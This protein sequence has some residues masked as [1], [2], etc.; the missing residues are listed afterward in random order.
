[1]KTQKDQLTE[2]QRLFCEFYV[3]PGKHNAALAARLAGYAAGSSHVTGCQLLQKP[4]IAG[5]VR[6]LEAAAAVEM[7]Y[8]RE[9][10]IVELLAAVEMARIMAIPST[11]VSGLVAIGKAAGLYAPQKAVHKTSPEQN[12]TQTK[13]SALSDHELLAIM[14]RAD[15]H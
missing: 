13:F 3:G 1:M 12:D 15:V 2:R 6:G 9:R 8:S 14:E 7:G 11:M 5:I 4:K 10:L